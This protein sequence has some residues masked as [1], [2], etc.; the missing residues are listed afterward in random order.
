MLILPWATRPSQRSRDLEAAGGGLSNWSVVVAPP[1]ISVVDARGHAFRRSAD[2]RLPD[3][4]DKRSFPA[5]WLVCHAGNLLTTGGRHLLAEA[6]RFQDGVREDLQVG[7]VKALAALGPVMRR[8]ASNRTADARF[9]EALTL[10]YRILFLLFAESRA[11][12]PLQ[13]PQYGPSYTLTPMCRD[14]S[15][16]AGRHVG[17]WDG[18]AA[19]TRLSRTGCDSSDLVAQPF[20]GRLFSKA[21]A[22]ALEADASARPTRLSTRRDSALAE[23]LVALG[24]RRGAGGREEISYAD[25]GVEQLGAVYERVLDLDPRELPEIGARISRI[26]ESRVHSRRRK[27]SGT[28]YTPQPLAEFVVRR[29]LSPLILN[30]TTDDILA[31]RIVD[32]AMGSGA[33]LVAACRFLADH[34]ERALVDEGR[35][36]E[37]DLDPD[38]RAGIRRLVAGRCL[39]GV[40]AN[41]VAVQLARLSLWLATL[42]RDK[43][44]SFFDHQLRCGDSLIGASPDDLWRLSQTDRRRRD[45]LLCSKPPVWRR[46]SDRS[47]IRGSSFAKGGTTRSVTCVS[48]SGCGPRSRVSDRRSGRGARPA[49]SGA[50]A[51][52]GTANRFSRR[53]QRCALRSM[54]CFATTGRCSRPGARS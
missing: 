6:S 23:A 48:A 15:S 18:L 47:R 21:A 30:A 46:Q 50:R 14:A 5:F 1:F 7:V 32:P 10:V 42:A 11:L 28:F 27:E 41:P 31:L 34:Y 39:A 38:A 52:S 16:G 53:H 22:P 20:N 2:F 13:H 33:F 26:L 24:T 12:A 43:P 37:S 40:D 49:I 4:I 3:A 36:A 51:G 8:D 29:T 25:L 35:C 9:A 54:L 19:I 44:L 17:M 45:R